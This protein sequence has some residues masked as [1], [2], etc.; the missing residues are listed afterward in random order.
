MAAPP[1]EV[2]ANHPDELDER[3]AG[4]ALAA[5]QLLPRVIVIIRLQF[6]QGRFRCLEAESDF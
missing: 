3:S 2:A 5:H 1:G 6:G 4:P